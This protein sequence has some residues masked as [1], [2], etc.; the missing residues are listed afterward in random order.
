MY[1]VWYGTRH[2]SRDIEMFHEFKN[3][4][5]TNIIKFKII[6]NTKDYKN[7]HKIILVW[8]VNQYQQ[9]TLKIN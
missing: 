1:F 9:L 4:L 5:Y 8:N 7:V 3:I 6:E 2:K